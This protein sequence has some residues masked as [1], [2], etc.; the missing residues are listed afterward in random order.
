MK[1]ENYRW[2]MISINISCFVAQDSWFANLSTDEPE[3]IY[4]IDFEMTSD[5]VG[6]ML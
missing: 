5:P 6:L 2:N 4:H 1:T 3:I